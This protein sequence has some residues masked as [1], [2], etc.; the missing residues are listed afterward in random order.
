MTKTSKKLFVVVVAVLLTMVVALV[1]VG[2]NETPDETKKEKFTIWCTEEIVELTT[3][4]MEQFVAENADFPYEIVVQPVGENDAATNMITDV[5][6]GGDVYCFAQDQIARLVTAGALAEVN[7]AFVE[8]VKANN[9]AGAVSAATVGGK[10]YAYPLTSDNG[11]FVYYDKSI[12]DEADFA[13][14]TTLIAAVKEHTGKNIAFNLSQGGGWYTASYFFGAG[15]ASNWQT[16]AEGNFVNYAD[17]MGG[18]KG[19]IALQ[20]MA[21]L[22]NSG[23]WVDSSEASAFSSNAAVLVS[24]AWVYNNVVELLG[25]NIA[26][27]KL[28][29]YNVGDNNYQLG[30]FSG[31]KLVGVRPQTDAT[32][33]AWGQSVAN[34]LTGE[35]CQN[36]RFAAKAWGPS[37]KNAQASDAVKANIA[38]AALAAQ[39]AHGTPQGQYPAT[40]W[41]TLSG[42]TAATHALGTTTL[43][44]DQMNTILSNYNKGIDEILHPSFVGWSVVG[45]LADA[46]WNNKGGDADDVTKEDAGKGK[47]NLGPAQ[48]TWAD[49]TD[50]EPLKGIWT[51]D[52]EVT[53]GDYMGFRVVQY[54]T[55]DYNIG[56]TN[57][58]DDSVEATGNADNNVQVTEAGIYTITLDTTSGDPATY[59]LKVV[60]KAA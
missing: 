33:A 8:G 31:N 36:E 6:A 39:S 53:A 37:N 16:D 7:S 47:Y 46:S 9:D 21:E 24:G 54:N 19:K 20:G 48:N 5:T 23:I 45:T 25:E 22:V 44:D 27:R 59:T 41:D 43:T 29:S 55:W 60:K 18:E 12:L 38:L 10:L 26:C 14:Q 51:M 17:T 50:A 49:K 57:L 1:A 52:I 3:T 4:Q 30:S 42:M 56:F 15:A 32:K 13:N 34:Y 11:Y 58:T 40:W 28:W 35:E 2:C